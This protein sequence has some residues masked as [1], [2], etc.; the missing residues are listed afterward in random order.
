MAVPVLQMVQKAGTRLGS[1][2]QREGLNRL[3][4]I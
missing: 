2:L 4:D 3:V 1:L